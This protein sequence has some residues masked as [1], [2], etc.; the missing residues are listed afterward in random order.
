MQYPSHFNGTT[1]EFLERLRKSKIGYVIVNPYTEFQ[2]KVRVGGAK[3]SVTFSLNPTME[4][5]THEPVW[6]VEC[7]VGESL[8]YKFIKRDKLL[9]YF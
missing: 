2:P 9:S 5:H 6:C 3:G 4:Q 1:K 7:N 8:E